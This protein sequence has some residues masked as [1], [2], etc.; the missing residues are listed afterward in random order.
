ML[1]FSLTPAAAKR[2]IG[3]GMAG[4]PEIKNALKSGTIAVVAGTTNG[5]VAEEILKSI[6]QT[7]NFS[8]KRFF[9]GIT[10]P[11][12]YKVTE[13]GRLAD[14]SGFKG[15]VII[16]DGLLLENKTLEDVADSLKEG[17]ILV[18]GGNAL[19]LANRK[20]AVLIGNPTGGT[21]FVS[22]RAAVGRRV[23]LIMPIGLE[24]RVDGDLD[25]I[26]RR[27]NSP[28][29]KGLRLMPAPGE[30]F[31]ELDAIAV[32]TGATA[33]LIGAGGVSGAEGA[34][35]LAVSGGPEAE[36]KAEQLIKSVEAEPAFVV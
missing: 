17:D 11:A 4:H 32:L 14:E 22:L 1:Q 15:D 30:V 31:T 28:G 23:R 29:S 34:V 12:G 16:K 5:Y 10:L 18:K 24:K 27:V 13:Q 35:Y 2:L 26:A 21:I 36:R 6:G 9:R 3:K 33:E 19:D 25:A 20:A 7:R 8:R